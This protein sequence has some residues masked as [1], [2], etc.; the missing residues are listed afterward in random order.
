MRMGMGMGGGWQGHGGLQ[1]RFPAAEGCVTVQKQSTLSN[2]NR[3]LCL[4]AL[5]RFMVSLRPDGEGKQ[6]LGSAA[7]ARQHRE[8]F[9]A[10]WEGEET[11]SW[12]HQGPSRSQGTL[13]GWCH[14]YTGDDAQRPSKP[15]TRRLRGTSSPPAVLDGNKT[16]L[17]QRPLPVQVSPVPP[18]LPA[19]FP[20]ADSGLQPPRP[21]R[22][23]HLPT[24]SHL[25]LLP[26]G[27]AQRPL[28][29]APCW[30]APP[31]LPAFPAPN[32]DK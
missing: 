22:L 28:K 2:N 19:G 26:G 27:K 17:W 25:S 10:P 8:R 32:E 13:A 18:P 3:S 14:L 4:L 7:A 23:T 31:L 9:A 16:P 5:P 15:N 1:P 24:H 20:P 6:L 21:A 29:R 11:L 12:S 30:A